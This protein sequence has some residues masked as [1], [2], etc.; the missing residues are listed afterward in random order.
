MFRKYPDHVFTFFAADFAPKL[1]PGVS[2]VAQT[3]F[4]KH[5]PKALQATLP[6][7]FNFG[8][9]SERRLAILTHQRLAFQTLGLDAWESRLAEYE[10]MASDCLKTL[11]IEEATRV[12]F[13]VMAFLPLGMTHPEMCRLMF[14][15]FLA[16]EVELAEVCPGVCDP[17]VHLE[18]K[19]GEM[20][21]IVQVTSMSSEQIATAFLKVPN[22]A[23]F[24]ENELLD[25]RLRECHSQ[26]TAK[27]SLMVDV[28][29]FMRNAACSG[30]G[31]FLRESL[32]Q[33]EDIVNA[34]ARRLTSK[35]K[36]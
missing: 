9:P 16:A 31:R 7:S 34:C 35:P 20:E 23:L 36:A 14:G 5:K 10:R 6:S 28:D 4:E 33:A 26:L 2:E 22:L 19:H 21:C 18:G 3:I 17:L 13:K 12:G 29:L 27:A 11:E 25:G 8:W 24:V 30:I 32:R 1:G 15:S